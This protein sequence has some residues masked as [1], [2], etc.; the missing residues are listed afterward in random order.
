MKLRLRFEDDGSSRVIDLPEGA[1]LS[2]LLSL[3]NPVTDIESIKVGRS[4]IPF[5][6]SEPSKSLSE[7][8]VR[9]LDTL[10]VKHTST[11]A[12]P[13]AKEPTPTPVIAEEEPRM[14]IRSIPDDNS[15][16][17]NAIAYV[18]ASQPLYTPSQLRTIVAN[19]ILSDPL[20]FNKTLLEQAPEDY[21]QWILL[22]NSWGGAIEL[23]ILAEWFDVQIASVDVQTGRIDLFGS[24]L[25]GER[26]YVMYS[27]IHYDALALNPGPSFPPDCD[28][29]R[30][31][32]EDTLAELEVK[33]L[34]EG[35]R[36]RHQYTDLARFT[37]KCSICYEALI[38]EGDARR[39]AKDTGHTDFVEF[40]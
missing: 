3:I 4:N 34:A 18:L 13:P 39:H 37:L 24:E 22:E 29:T 7:L 27:G 2:T 14:M 32:P 16:L 6:I 1:P 35:A 17:F 38:G 30:F 11:T 10:F 8:G 15:C 31:D 20:R 23:G 19:C 26:V 33:K 9:N 21:V 12:K 40:N 36:K 28:V 5:S 25:A